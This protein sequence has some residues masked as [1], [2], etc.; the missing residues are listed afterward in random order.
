VTK[1]KGKHLVFD[2]DFSFNKALLVCRLL[3]RGLIKSFQPH[4]NFKHK[5]NLVLLT[6]KSK[7]GLTS[8][9][10]MSRAH[11]FFVDLNFHLHL[12]DKYFI[13]TA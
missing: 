5:L 2:V 10:N 11:Y 4:Q 6:P 3:D 12:P 9:L 7:K 13:L 1:P 8:I